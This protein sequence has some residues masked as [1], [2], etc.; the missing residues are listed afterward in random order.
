[1]LEFIEYK[2]VGFK[3]GKLSLNGTHPVRPLRRTSTPPSE[4]VFLGATHDGSVD[5]PI[6]IPAKAG[7]QTVQIGCH[8]NEDEMG[9]H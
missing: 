6:V 5:L 7:I 1:M 3:R 4:G 9:S 2:W 8:N